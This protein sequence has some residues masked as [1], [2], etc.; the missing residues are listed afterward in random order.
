MRNLD[1][2]KLDCGYIIT[3][4]TISKSYYEWSAYSWQK[5]NG[6]TSDLSDLGLSEPLW[7]YSNVST[8]AGVVAAQSESTYTLNLK[9]YIETL[10]K[11]DI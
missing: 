3:L 8:G 9:E 2:D 11:S 10:L 1:P 6:F 4:H 7:G 5:D